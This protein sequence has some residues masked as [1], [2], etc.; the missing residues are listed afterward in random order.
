M[1]K[2]ARP[3]LT[4]ILAMLCAAIVVGCSAATPDVATAP[5]PA[6]TPS[7]SATSSPRAST[8]PPTTPRITESPAQGTTTRVSP[9]PSEPGSADPT[10]TGSG[11][12]PTDLSGAVYGYITAVDVPASQLTVDKVDWF[13]G[14]AAEQAC[15]EDGV[16][17]EA[18]LNEWCSLYYFRNVNPALRVVTVDPQ[19]AVT[20]LDGN[21]PTPGDLASLADRITTPTGSTR[22][23]RLTVVD[24]V[25]TEVTEIYQP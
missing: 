12:L 17:Q 8:A 3:L 14:A 10:P 4:A 25:V 20:T 2:A 7:S 16:P 9:T 21:V 22:P 5:T 11:V 15:A 13:D 1:T 18:R 6:T 23:Y 24:G 19:V